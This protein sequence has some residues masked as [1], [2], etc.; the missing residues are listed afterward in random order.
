M[1]RGHRG[2]CR[3]A[4]AYGGMTGFQ[5]RVI[6]GVLLGEG[7]AVRNVGQIEGDIVC[8]GSNADVVATNG[9]GLE[10]AAEVDVPVVVATN[11]PALAV[12]NG[13][14]AFPN[15]GLAF[16]SE[17]LLS[18]P[19][20]EVADKTYGLDGDELVGEG[21]DVCRQEVYALGCVDVGC[22]TGGAQGTGFGADAVIGTAPGCFGAELEFA[23]K[24][25]ECAVIAFADLGKGPCR[26]GL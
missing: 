13:E 21:G 6:R 1:R 25:Q 2:G 15:H 24:S 4:L 14:L 10:V 20:V 9:E 3:D 5:G 23:V 22:V 19:S 18:A 8:S 26:S 16:A 17:V 11:L 7:D 12:G